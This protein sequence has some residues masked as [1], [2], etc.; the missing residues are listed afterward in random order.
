MNI[1]LFAEPISVTPDETI[2]K[3]ITV[4]SC[5]TIFM[6]LLMKQKPNAAK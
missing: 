1:L 5:I 6:L 3:V 4:V 2:L